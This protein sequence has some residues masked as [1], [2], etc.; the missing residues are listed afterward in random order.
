[1]WKLTNIKCLFLSLWQILKYT[2]IAK[3]ALNDVTSITV[4]MIVPWFQDYKKL[5]S[6]STQL[7]KKLQLFLKLKCWK[8]KIF[9]ALEPSNVV[10]TLLIN[11]KMPTIVG[12][13]AFM[14]RVNFS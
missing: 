6:C 10:F 2:E 5:L 1:M 3:V 13:L 11:V 7:S 8:I 9:H 14:S 12:I 4:C